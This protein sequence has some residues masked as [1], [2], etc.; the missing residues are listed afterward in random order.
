M[1]KFSLFCLFSSILCF[2]VFFVSCS[3]DNDDNGSYSISSKKIVSINGNGGKLNFFY[4]SKDNLVG[5]SN[6]KKTINFNYNDNKLSSNVFRATIENGRVSTF[7]LDKGTYFSCNIKYSNNGKIES[8]SNI[9]GSNVNDYYLT[10]DGQNVS[11]VEHW[12]NGVLY[13]WVKYTYT[14][15][16][17]G[18]ISCLG[19]F[20]PFGEFDFLDGLEESAI[21]YTGLCGNLSINLPETAESWSKYYEK[22]GLNNNN[23]TR[24]RN[25]SYK[26]NDDDYPIEIS[27]IGSDFLDEINLFLTVSWE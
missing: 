9:Y 14:H 8:I 25:Y 4:D 10:W 27:I 3:N 21:F 5:L 20:N 11:K 16:K 18:Y 19:Y 26:I 24:F 23:E 17:A 22:G 2:V 13:G 6:M 1:K 12:C 7:E 15:Y